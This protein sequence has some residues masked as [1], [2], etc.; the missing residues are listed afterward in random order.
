MSI[1]Y[2]SIEEIDSSEARYKNVI[3]KNNNLIIPYINLAVSNHPLND[4]GNNL[5]LDYSYMVFLDVTYLTVFIRAN[6]YIVVD[7]KKNEDPFYFGGVYL[8]YEGYIYNDLEIC[9]KKAYLRTLPFTQLSFDM[10]VHSES[11][12]LNKNMNSSSVEKFFEGI[13]MPIEIRQLI[14][15]SLSAESHEA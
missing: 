8:D 4:S 5:F 7:I 3:F 12:I 15:P 14:T 13:Y 11:Q 2:K 9:C 6:R 1:Y 10:W